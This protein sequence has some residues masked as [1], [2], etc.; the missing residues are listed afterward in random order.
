[1]AMSAAETLYRK[2]RKGKEA[3]FTGQPSEQV[4]TNE[5]VTPG[6]KR[7]YYVL[8]NI[9]G[10]IPEEA[11]DHPMAKMLFTFLR[12]GK[13]DIKRIPWPLIEHLSRQL[14][15]AFLWVADG[16]LTEEDGS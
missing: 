14:G 10:Q 11:R 13:K 6:H 3:Q 7:L 4:T 15:E 2:H 8:D 12:E 9:A 16:E 1:M 5:S